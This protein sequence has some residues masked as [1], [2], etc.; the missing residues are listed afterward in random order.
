MFLCCSIKYI[1]SQEAKN[2]HADNNS[3]KVYNLCAVHHM[4][5]VYLV[6]PTRVHLLKD[7]IWERAST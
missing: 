3:D 2:G 4:I 5:Y 7:K 6:Y 1:S